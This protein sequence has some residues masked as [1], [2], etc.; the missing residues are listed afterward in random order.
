[1]SVILVV[2]PS[3][4]GVLLGMLLRGYSTDV[5]FQVALITIIVLFAKNPILIIE[6]AKGLQA[7]G[8][9]A[10]QAALAAAHL[11]FGPIVMT[12]LTFIL[13]VVPLFIASASPANAMAAADVQ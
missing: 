5:Y 7:Q 2:S 8:K 12:S 10:V 4:L 13:G 6:F 3:V 1:M 11:R 9:T